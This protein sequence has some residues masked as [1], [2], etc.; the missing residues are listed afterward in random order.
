MSLRPAEE[1]TDGRSY[2]R[3]FHFIRVRR[4]REEEARK[5]RGP[6]KPAAIIPAPRGT[7]P[8]P[9]AQVPADGLFPLDNPRTDQWSISAVVK[10][11][12]LL[13]Q[14]DATVVSLT[15]GRWTVALNRSQLAREALGMPV[16]DETI[17]ETTA[18]RRK[19]RNYALRVF[20]EAAEPNAGGPST[21]T[22]PTLTAY[23]T[24]SPNP[25]D[26]IPLNDTSAAVHAGELP[27][28]FL[29]T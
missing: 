7:L 16:S 28:M 21:L 4:D 13:T 27:R 14:D 19:N 6:A 5:R 8:L 17:G 22:L 11:W 9:S 25:L 23:L 15:V 2:R 29:Q 18:D 10:L 12:D 26:F 1:A 24:R 20:N 3:S